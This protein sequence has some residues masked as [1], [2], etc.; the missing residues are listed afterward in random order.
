MSKISD[1]AHSNGLAMKDLADMSGIKYTTLMTFASKDITEWS[2]ENKRSVASALD[3]ALVDFDKIMKSR[4]L[5][6]F[7]KWVGGKRQLLPN[8]VSF[9]PKSYKK[10]YEP[11]LGGGA[12]LFRLAPKKAVI[13]DSNEELVNAYIQVRDNLEELVQSLKKHQDKD[14]KEYYLKVRSYDRDGSILKMSNVER[15]S[16]FIYLNKAGYN[17]LWRVNSKGQHNVPYGSHKNLRLVSDSLLA[18]SNYLRERDILITNLDYQK[19]VERADTG[20]FVYFDPPYIP[21]N[22]TSSFT[23]YTKSGFGMV[24]QE[25]LRDLVLSLTKRGVQVMLSNSDT[26][27]THELYAGKEFHIHRV[28]ATRSINSKSTGR[29]RIGELVITNY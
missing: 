17:G 28:K 5:T 8:L 9:L 18:D 14:S 13:N 3:M 1:L 4:P 24:Q 7:I 25:Q 20:D 27:L 19:A 29:G 21:V 22:L 10:Y 15:A 12:L 16:R 2:L 23:S 26:K 6:P 11:F